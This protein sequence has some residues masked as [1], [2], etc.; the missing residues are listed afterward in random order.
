MRFIEI[1][2]GMG[3]EAGIGMGS[4]DGRWEGEGERNACKSIG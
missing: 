2:W 4:G 3:G 1:Y